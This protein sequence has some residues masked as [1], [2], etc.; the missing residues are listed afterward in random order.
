[1]F[2]IDLQYTAALEQIDGSMKEHMKFLDACYKANLFISSGRKVPRTGGII[3][4]VG[5]S[6]EAL[7]EVMRQDPFYQRGLMQFTI[8]EFQASQSRPDFRKVLEG[9]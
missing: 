7:E 4:A 8:T 9:M 3:L 6:K 1:M 2:V 5:K